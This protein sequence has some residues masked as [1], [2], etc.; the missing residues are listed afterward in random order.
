[1]KPTIPYAREVLTF[2]LLTTMQKKELLQ[3]CT[4]ALDE[5]E[6]LAKKYRMDKEKLKEIQTVT[7]EVIGIIKHLK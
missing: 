2:N 6:K 3:K 4:D 1:M 5:C 7:D